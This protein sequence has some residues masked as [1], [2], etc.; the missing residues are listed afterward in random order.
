LDLR[1]RK[2][3]ETGEDCMHNLYASSIIIRVEKSRR[4]GWER[5]V[6]RMGK[7]RNVHR[8]DWKA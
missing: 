3:R 6:A 1:G 5:Y 8:I 7:M 2:W 4:I